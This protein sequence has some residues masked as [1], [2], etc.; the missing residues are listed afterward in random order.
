MIQTTTGC[1]V[2]TI[3]FPLSMSSSGD[4]LLS[5]RSHVLALTETKKDTRPFGVKRIAYCNSETKEEA[6]KQN[7]SNPQN[8]QPVTC[9]IHLLLLL[10]FFSF[11]LLHTCIICRYIISTQNFNFKFKFN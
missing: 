4:F 9:S 10:Q 7:K 2:I 5:S 1:S 11:T 8:H 6:I 3:E